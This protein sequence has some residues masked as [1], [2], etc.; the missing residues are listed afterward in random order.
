MGAQKTDQKKKG[1]GERLVEKQEDYRY[2][3]EW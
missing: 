1:Q 3:C 2:Q